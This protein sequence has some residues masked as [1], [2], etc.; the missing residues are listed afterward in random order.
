[1]A[2]QAPRSETAP[3]EVVLDAPEEAKQIKDVVEHDEMKVGDKYFLVAAHWYSTWNDYTACS[4]D[5][6]S[7]DVLPSRPG[8]IDND[9]LLEDDGSLRAEL[10]EKNDY[11]LLPE[12]AWNL[13]YS[14]YGGRPVERRVIAN[15]LQQT[16]QVE[17]YPITVKVRSR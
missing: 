17:L 16:P 15:G 1:M 11:E 6:V 2:E 13:L 3:E 12:R 7:S 10:V 9:I 8:P 14:W 5:L 4:A